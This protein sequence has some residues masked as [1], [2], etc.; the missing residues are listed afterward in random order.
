M[1]TS[2]RQKL[3]ILFMLISAGSAS[4]Q[5]TLRF[6]LPEAVAYAMQNSYV[7][8]NSSLDVEAA[9]KKVWET[10]ATGLPQVSGTANYSDNLNLPVQLVPAEFF[11]GNKGEY[12]EVSFTQK[13]SSDF[14][15]KVDQ[16]I[17]DGS[18]IVGVSSAKL[19]LQLS[20]QAKE[21]SEIEIRHAVEQAYY[22]ALVARENLAVLQENLANN[23]KQFTDTKAMFENG[24]VEEQDVDQFKLIVQNSENEIIKA[25]REI[26]VAEMVLKYTMGVEVATPV[27]LTDNLADFISPLLLTEEDTTVFDLTTHIDYR[28][29]D[30]QRMSQIK[31]LKLEQSAY[32][33]PVKCVLQLE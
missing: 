15:F 21:K 31:L 1:K 28:I 24:F 19:Y 32:L 11:G 17:F 33:P 4:A 29:S 7:I 20:D 2:V 22:G 9:K 8:R 13:Y 5:D 18:Y 6:S 10:I 26:R 3:L 30:S 16:L 23:E 14:G 27:A 25:E 12:I